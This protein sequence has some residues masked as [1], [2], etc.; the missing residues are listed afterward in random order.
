MR[1]DSKPAFPYTG[2][3]DWGMTIRDYFA[4]H[5]IGHLA[6]SPLRQENTLE[7]DVIYAYRVADAML[8]ERSK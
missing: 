8:Q 3:G 1:D 5:L 6:A 2:C 4:A 7:H